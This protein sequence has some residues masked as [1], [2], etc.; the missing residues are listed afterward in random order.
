VQAL[1]SWYDANDRFI[2]SSRSYLD[3]KQLLPGQTSP[4]SVWAD[5]NPA[6]KTARL[7]FIMGGRELAVLFPPKK[8]LSVKEAQQ[9]LKECGYDP[10]PIDGV[11]GLKTRG[12]LREYL[13]WNSL[14]VT[15][16]LDTATQRALQEEKR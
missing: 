6:M 7:R 10:G 2:T 13:R 14:P 15:G 1:V 9:I 5:Y 8:R 3:L 4:F 16:N 12:A 11:M